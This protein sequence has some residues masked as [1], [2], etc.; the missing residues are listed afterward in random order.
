MTTR[1]VAIVFFNCGVCFQLQATSLYDTFPTYTNPGVYSATSVLQRKQA[2][3]VV[4]NPIM[5]PHTCSIHAL[6][7]LPLGSA[8]QNT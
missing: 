2:P 1:V 6:F 3:V 5:R 4:I 8:L 7:C